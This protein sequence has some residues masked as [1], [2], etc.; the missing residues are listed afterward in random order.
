LSK[1]RPEVYKRI[2]QIR[3]RNPLYLD[4]TGAFIAKTIDKYTDWEGGVAGFR[5]IHKDRIFYGGISMQ[6][7]NLATFHKTSHDEVEAKAL[8]GLKDIVDVF[9]QPIAQR[10]GYRIIYLFNGIDAGRSFR[11]INAFAEPNIP[12]CEFLEDYKV[13]RQ[14]L[15]L[16]YNNKNNYINLKLLYGT[17]EVKKEPLSREEK[18]GLIVDVDVYKIFDAETHLTSDL[19]DKDIVTF[20]NNAIK[21]QN[22]IIQKIQNLVKENA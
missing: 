18:K 17:I 12:K 16:R 21:N 3:L 5:F 11:I 2:F 14:E 6:D 22:L 1:T 7:F 9:E 19:I 13:D 8:E 15:A 4:K 10:V 20:L